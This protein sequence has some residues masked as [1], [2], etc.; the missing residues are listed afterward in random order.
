M[1]GL[2]IDP[3]NM[4]I[5]EVNY[6]GNWKTIKDHIGNG[7]TIFEC[8]INLDNGDSFYTD[9][10]GLYHDN[11][12]GLHRHDWR[13]PLV[14]RILVL[15]LDKETGDTIDAVSTIEELASEHNLICKNDPGLIQYF[16]HFN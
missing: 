11:I 15:G 7:C 8:P 3:S 4:S 5:T 14:G 13:F 9:E 16:K 10:E 1:R 6:D 2:L 12:G